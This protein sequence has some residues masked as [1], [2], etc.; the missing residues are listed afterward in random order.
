VAQL[1]GRAAELSRI[2]EALGPRGQPRIAIYGPPGVGKSALALTA[3]EQLR[4]RCGDGQLFVNLGGRAGA[5]TGAALLALLLRAL[6][7]PGMAVP[8]GEAERVVM[9]R[10]LVGGAALMLVLDDVAGEAQVRSVL[11]ARWSAVILTSRC[12]LS[13]LEDTP[14]LRLGVLGEP[15][16]LRLL[17]NTAPAQVAADPLG[18]RRIAAACGGLP[19]ALRLAGAKLAARPHWTASRLAVR[20][21]DEFLR[22]D[23]LQV[24]D[25]AVRA[26]FEISYTVLN[27]LSQRAFQILGVLGHVGVDPWLA[28]AALDLFEPEALDCI[29]DLVAAQLLDV[30]RCPPV[31]YRLHDLL[32]VFARERFDPRHEPDGITGIARRVAEAFL[33]VAL[34]AEQALCCQEAHSCGV[35]REF[36]VPAGVVPDTARLPET[37]DA[38]PDA[39]EWL[40]A[41]KIA[42]QAAVQ[43]VH[44][45]GLWAHCWALGRALLPALVA[46]GHHDEWWLVSRL[47]LDAAQRAGQPAWGAA[48]PTGFGGPHLRCGGKRRSQFAFETRR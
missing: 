25:D 24:G 27:P 6:G 43:A 7:W 30:S 22:L 2:S 48:I 17:A 11:S 15:V 47:A 38:D 3:A 28:G 10:R 32:R 45:Q 12:L 21:A 19:L 9:L 18:A 8:D 36:T 20:L 26:S 42:A 13:A 46:G 1:V 16:A 44:T 40:S 39:V 5:M 23:E 37:T 4:E 34:K 33:A 31:E 41:R 29:D 35:P 14:H